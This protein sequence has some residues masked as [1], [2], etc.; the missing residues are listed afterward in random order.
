TTIIRRREVN[1]AS[2]YRVRIGNYWTKR[3]QE[4]GCPSIKLQDIKDIPETRSQNMGCF[5]SD[6]LEY[7]YF[8]IINIG[9]SRFSGTVYN[10]HCE[11][12][13]YL[14]RHITTH[15]CDPSDHDQKKKKAGNDVSDLALAIVSKPFGLE[16]PRLVLEYVDRPEMLDQFFEQAAM[17]L[18]WYNNTQVLVEDNRA[19]MVNYF[20]T[21][22]PALLPLVPSSI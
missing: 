9:V 3:L 14:C 5:F 1:Q 21:N 16:A 4:V 7:I 22:Y 2:A 17:A 19:R 18:R 15:N 8:Q 10:F 20:K 13:T 11:T 6:D 12:S